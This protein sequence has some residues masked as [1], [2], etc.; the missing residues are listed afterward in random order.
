MRRRSVPCVAGCCGPKLI[1]ISCS[2]RPGSIE[3]ARSP[4][5][6][7]GMASSWARP[8]ART[9]R[10]GSVAMLGLH[11]ALAALQDDEVVALA[12]AAERVI[13]AEREAAVVFRHEDPLEIRVALELDPEHVE[14]FALAPVGRVPHGRRAR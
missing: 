7:T 13:L 10:V 5:E 12:P 2:E 8:V 1:T 9:P 4:K 14:H 6:A 11:F 3:A